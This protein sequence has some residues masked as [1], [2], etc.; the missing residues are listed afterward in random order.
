[1]NNDVLEELVKDLND[2]LKVE[3]V[4]D[5]QFRDDRYHEKPLEEDNFNSIPKGS[6]DRTVSYIDGGNKELYSSPT[7]SIHLV[8]VYFN[9]FESGNRKD[10]VQIPQKID[11][12]TLAKAYRKNDEIYYK[13]KIYPLKEE[14]ERF[15]PSEED[16]DFNSFDKSF[17]SGIYRGPI[18]K[19]CR[20][21]RRFAEWKI[22][23]EIAE[24][25]LSE[26]DMVVG[27]GILHTSVPNEAIYASE[28]YEK[29]M[30]NGVVVSKLAKT[31]KLYTTTGKNLVK[32]IKDLGDNFLPEQEWYYYP[33]A[34]NEHPSHKAEIYFV[35]LYKNS[36]YVFRYEIYRDWAREANK[37]EIES[38]ISSISENSKDIK[39]P[40]YPYGL[41]DADKMASIS[42]KEAER[43]RAMLKAHAS[44]NKYW[45]EIE[46][47]LTTTNAH[48]KLDKF[49]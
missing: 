4:G 32:A 36:D 5:P 15:L 2:S 46:K 48:E 27:D 28:A 13:G 18:N 16:L 35:K 41:V 25:E 23:G 19:L 43:Y 44:G 7:F 24:K 39:F 6:E 21:A 9:L 22:A 1:M 47:H 42:E 8:R 34:E 40:G 10:P 49:K 33:V 37:K 14:E 12:Y 20:S 3:D 38:V 45:E 30:E 29:G 31:T 17:R 11:F 26:G